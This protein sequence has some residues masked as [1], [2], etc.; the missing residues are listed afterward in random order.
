M[1]TLAVRAVAR[2]DAAAV[3]AARAMLPRTGPE[4]RTQHLGCALHHVTDGQH[5][6]P[7]LQKAD[8]L[9][10]PGAGS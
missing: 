10:V 6:A 4:G 5:G 3:S 2:L 8:G 9:L 1:A 7:F